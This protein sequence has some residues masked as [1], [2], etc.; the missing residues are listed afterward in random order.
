MA[1]GDKYTSV[2]SDEQGGWG[3]SEVGV[4]VLSSWLFSF[5]SAIVILRDKMQ[6]V[7]ENVYGG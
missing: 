5:L 6:H 4:Q 3:E 2:N 1:S 7:G